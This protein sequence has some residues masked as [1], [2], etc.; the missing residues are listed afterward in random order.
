MSVR[1]WSDH[2]VIDP[3]RLLPGEGDEIDPADWF[4]DGH[5]IDGLERMPQA[6]KEKRDRGF[7]VPEQI[8]HRQHKQDLA[9]EAEDRLVAAAEAKVKAGRRVLPPDEFEV[10]AAFLFKE[11]PRLKRAALRTGY[12]AMGDGTRLVRGEKKATET[13]G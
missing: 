8:V 13:G 5:P 9:R 6:R 3:K 1:P 4:V 11:M 2:I 10:F 7:S 12:V